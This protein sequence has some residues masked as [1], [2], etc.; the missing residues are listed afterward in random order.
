M[1]EPVVSYDRKGFIINGKRV[2]LIGGEFHYFR[3][4]AAEWEDRLKKMKRMGA[5]LISVYIAWNMHEPEEGKERW[6]GDYDLD[7]FLTLCEKYG[8]YVLIKPGPYICAELD[9]GGHP[10]WLIA[11]IARKELRLRMLDDGYLK[12]CRKW[13]RTVSEKIH[14]HLITH[15]GSII[16]AQ[17]ENEY[18]HLIEYGEETITVQNAVDY[19]LT[20]K[21]MMEDCGI[22]VP[23]FANE[24]AFLRGKGIIDARTYYPYIPGLWM[25]EYRLYED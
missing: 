4:P 9:F 19:F 11:K 10:D 17:I 18:D 15:G 25:G 20:L 14:S 12:V 8:F 2:F 6:D 24:A 13:Y 3:V 1:N 21:G 23:K 22:D 5:N 16:A 7:R